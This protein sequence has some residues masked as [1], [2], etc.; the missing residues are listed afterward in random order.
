MLTLFPLVLLGGGDPIAGHLDDQP[1]VRELSHLHSII[2]LKNII[3][4]II[5]IN[6]E[7][8]CFI[9]TLSEYCK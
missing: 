7:S 8:M 5:K 4:K 3:N 2:G 6:I 9:I 1:I